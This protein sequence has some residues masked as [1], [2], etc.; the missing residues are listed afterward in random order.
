M[1]VTITRTIPDLTRLSLLTRADMREIGNLARE[2]VIRRTASGLDSSGRN[3][4]A[5]SPGYAERKG[6]ELG[7]TEPN[8]QVSGAMLNAL[9]IVDVTEDSVTLGFA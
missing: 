4:Q 9:Q 2:R 8:L 5:Y 6:K 3:F 1:S 7:V